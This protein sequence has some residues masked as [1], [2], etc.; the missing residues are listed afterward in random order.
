MN[1]YKELIADLRYASERYNELY[2]L[3]L[4]CGS[5]D[6]TCNHK[7]CHAVHGCEWEWRGVQET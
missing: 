2:A 3:Y 5:V 4:D 7:N 1:D 6:S